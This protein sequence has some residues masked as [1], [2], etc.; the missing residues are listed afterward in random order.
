MSRRRAIVVAQCLVLP[1]RGQVRCPLSA[2]ILRS[3][4]LTRPTN[5][6]P[7]AFRKAAGSRALPLRGDSTR[8]S[9]ASLLQRTS[10]RSAAQK[11]EM[12]SSR[13]QSRVSGNGGSFGVPLDSQ[14]K[15]SATRKRPLL[16]KGPPSEREWP[17]RALFHPG[18]PLYTR[19][20]DRLLASPCSHFCDR[21]H[22]ALSRACSLSA[23]VRQR[24]DLED[25]ARADIS[26]RP[27]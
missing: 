20:P 24:T 15:H 11:R 21:M 27:R 19:W 13:A 10:F 25:L 12:I 6:M 4:C 22:F 9:F 7:S 14:K 18:P 2:P 17:A 5:T 23:S 16:R 8:P 26:T 3:R 1:P